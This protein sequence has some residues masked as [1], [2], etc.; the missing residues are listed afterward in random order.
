[1]LFFTSVYL[2]N[3]GFAFE[4]ESLYIALA[5]V[6]GFLHRDPIASANKVMG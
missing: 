6:T 2:G 5:V 1:M 3:E 4:A